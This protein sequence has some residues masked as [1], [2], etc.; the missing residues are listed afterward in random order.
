MTNRKHSKFDFVAR[1]AIP[2]EAEAAVRDAYE[3]EED[4]RLAL[5]LCIP[6]SA[7][8]AKLKARY[9]SRSMPFQDLWHAEDES[10]GRKLIEMF[11][12]VPA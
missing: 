12:T 7:D 8:E 5:V 11:N 10:F 2:L 1:E 4:A 6:L 9:M 3:F